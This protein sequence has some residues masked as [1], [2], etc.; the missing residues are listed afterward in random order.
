MELVPL[1]LRAEEDHGLFDLEEAV[2]F[3]EMVEGID[4][5]ATEALALF[6]L[7]FLKVVR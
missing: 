7:S 3:W 4:K 1:G 2:L 6:V 5:G